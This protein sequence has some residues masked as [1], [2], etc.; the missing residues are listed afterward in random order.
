MIGDMTGREYADFRESVIT[1]KTWR[2][3]GDVCLLTL[4]VA[5]FVAVVY[6]II[7]IMI[8][9]FANDFLSA[10]LTPVYALMNFFF[11]TIDFFNRIPQ[12]WR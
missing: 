2:K 1:E 10:Y 12:N 4:I 9:V 6:A 11:D 8:N 3:L 7:G 5:I